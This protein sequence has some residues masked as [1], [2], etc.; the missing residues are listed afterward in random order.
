[1]NINITIVYYTKL[2]TRII[3]IMSTSTLTDQPTNTFLDEEKM[4]SDTESK[5]EPRLDEVKEMERSQNQTSFSFNPPLINNSSDYDMIHSNIPDVNYIFRFTLSNVNVSVANAIR[6]TV[7]SDI[8]T[9]VFKTTPYKE[10]D[11]QMF[12]NT[13]NLN[14]EILCGRISAIPIHIHPERTED[15]ENY[16]MELDVKNVTK[17][18]INVTTQDCKIRDKRTG[19]Y[20]DE[21]VVHEIFPPNPI[22]QEYIL[23]VKLRPKLSQTL[24]GSHIKMS[25]NF[26][27]QTSSVSGSFVVASICSYRNT[28]DE[29]KIKV[30]YEKI[31][32][33]VEDINEEGLT[34]HEISTHLKNWLILDSK[35][36]NIPDSFDFIIQSIGVFSNQDIV[37]R[38]CNNIILKLHHVSDQYRSG[39]ATVVET[40]TTMTNGYDITLEGVGHT[41]GKIIEYAILTHMYEG[42]KALTFCGF[43]KAHPHDTFCTIRVA[44]KSPTETMVVINN[45][46]ACIESLIV[47][48]SDI[49]NKIDNIHH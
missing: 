45:L 30:E 8:Q 6:R 18:T 35:R 27:I 39:A 2:L 42:T 46:L 48:Y 49:H 31:R 17:S 9:V 21:H 28:L 37:K 23:I 33:N 20:L 40:S 47:L 5:S 16:I 25:C 14:N 29:T 7:L 22:T 38:S 36:I 13:T 4:Y 43:R 24:V 3:T 34:P 11:A 41:I 12:I 32:R 44:Y 1:M 19:K 26:S 15:I 10:S